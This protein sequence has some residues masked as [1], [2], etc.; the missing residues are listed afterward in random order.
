MRAYF[1]PG[2]GVRVHCGREGM[3]GEFGSAS[4]SMEDQEAEKQQSRTQLSPFSLFLYPGPQPMA[5]DGASH[6]QDEF[7]FLG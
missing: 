3:V 6:D 5:W 4:G 1:G 2:S 7:S